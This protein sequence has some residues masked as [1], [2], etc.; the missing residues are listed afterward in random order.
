MHEAALCVS[1]REAA[2]FHVWHELHSPE[3]ELR[4]HE[5]AQKNGMHE[6]ALCVSMREAAQCQVWHVLNSPENNKPIHRQQ[7][8]PNSEHLSILR[9]R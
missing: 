8:T 9:R 6:A 5:A 3:T 1:M 7:R 2:Q 4:M